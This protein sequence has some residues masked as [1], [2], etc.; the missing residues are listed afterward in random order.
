MQKFLKH[1]IFILISTIIFLYLC[2]LI[3]TYVYLKSNPRNKFQY[4]LKTKNKSYDIVFIGSSR[5][6][7]HINA[8]L[9]SKLSNKVVMN[10]GVSG[11]G[12]NDNLLQLKLLFANHKVTNVFLQIDA[13]FENTKP[14]NI[15]IS[16]AMPF[17]NNIIINNHLKK[18]LKNFDYLNNIPFYKYAINDPK[19]GFREMFFSAIQKKTKNDFNFGYS[20]LNGNK[21]PLIGGKL[22][23]TILKEN[24]ILNQIINLCEKNKTQLT[25][26]VS[27]YC[28]KIKNIDYIV[29][30]KKKYPYLIDFSKGYDDNLFYNCSHLN[31]KGANKFTYDLYNV[32]KKIINN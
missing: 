29:K 25:L 5:V 30:L 21:L 23:K 15:S 14:S 8:K 31:N 4:I 19:I 18:N 3:Y 32:S 22:P 10:F 2:D 13:S 6:E 1:L 7:N 16:E 20:P 27:P 12:L 28:K 26:F 17:L 11:A 24:T 9:F